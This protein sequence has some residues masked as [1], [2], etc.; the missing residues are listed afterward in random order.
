MRRDRPLRTPGRTAR[1]EDDG[2]I[3]LVDG[4]VADRGAATTLDQAIE[5]RLDFDGAV[6]RAVRSH[7]SE[8]LSIRDQDPRLAAVQRMRDLASRPHRVHRGDD[9]AD[10]ERR[11][12]CDDPLRAVRGQDRDA[13]ARRDT[14][15]FAQHVG[16]R[17]DALQMLVVREAFVADDDVAEVAESG[18]VDQQL[19]RRPRPVLEHRHSLPED[20]LLGDLERGTRPG[21]VVRCL[22]CIHECAPRISSL[23]SPTRGVRRL[24]AHGDREN[25][26]GA[27]GYN[28]GGAP[29]TCSTGV[30]NPRATTCG[31]ANASSGV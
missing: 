20:E 3:V 26:Y 12:E 5:V 16:K 18:G 24:I 22:R 2:R 21:E 4:H 25:R 14:E 15:V 6:R 1:I 30:G 27:P 7:P 19:A 8:A 31:S 11:P 10:A 29:S 17:G 28:T 13:I 9:T 23:C